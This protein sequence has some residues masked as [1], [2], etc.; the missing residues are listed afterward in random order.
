MATTQKR[1]IV[2]ISHPDKNAGVFWMTVNTT[3]NRVSPEELANSFVRSAG[4]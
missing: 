1:V 4:A 2:Y 3:L